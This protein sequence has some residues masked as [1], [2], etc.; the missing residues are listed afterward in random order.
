VSTDLVAELR[1]VAPQDKQQLITDLFEQ[2][3]L[4]DV[5]TEKVASRRRA[6]GR[7]DVTL[8]VR[9]RKMYA[10]GKGKE[11]N[12]PMDET[13]WIGAFAAK[14]GDKT[15]AE[16]DV[17]ALQRMRIHSGLQTVTLITDR[18]PAWG[19][20]DPYN[21]LIDRNSDDNLVPAG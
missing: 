17:I 5:R 1:A 15:F 13:L 11:R 8:T 3:T 19:G 7:W 6:D 9:A 14:P 4:Y 20:A 2:I 10:D 12:T 16:R 21:E 18:K